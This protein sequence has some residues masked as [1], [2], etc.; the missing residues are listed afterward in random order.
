MKRERESS[1]APFNNPIDDRKVVREGGRGELGLESIQLEH[2]RV[3]EGEGRG[4]GKE[5][6]GAAWG[7]DDRLR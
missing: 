1:A 5:Y 4:R 7:V 2:R 6:G 3:G